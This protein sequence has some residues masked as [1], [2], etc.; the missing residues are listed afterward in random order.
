MLKIA[1]QERSRLQ[2][3]FQKN[4]SA[5]AAGANSAAGG[6]TL[7]NNPV[8]HSTAHMLP[9]APSGENVNG[10]NGVAGLF[11]HPS[12]ATFQPVFRDPSNVATNAGPASFQ[13][14]SGSG[15]MNEQQYE[16][17][18]NPNYVADRQ[19]EWEEMQHKINHL[20]EAEQ[21]HGQQVLHGSAQTV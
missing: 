16:V 18:L 21:I 4:F 7:L 12:A 5:H 10:Q 20:E 3:E 8:D 11:L 19:W 17:T 14:L 13:C 2:V 15:L 1:I 6:A 9:T